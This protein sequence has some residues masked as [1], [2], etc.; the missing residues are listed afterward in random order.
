MDGKEEI[1]LRVIGDFRALLER[2]ERV[3]VARID[4]FGSRQPLLDELAQ[5]QGHIQAQVF[6]HQSRGADRAGIMAAVP[7]VDHDAADLQSQRARQ[8]MLAVASE[9]GSWRRAHF[10]RLVVRRFL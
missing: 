7:G 10:L 8:G 3:V 1:G 5:A 2:D 9:F 6:F 4:H